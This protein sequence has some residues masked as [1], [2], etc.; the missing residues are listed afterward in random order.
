MNISFIYRDK[1][2]LIFAILFLIVSSFVMV[3]INSRFLEQIEEG[4]VRDVETELGLRIHELENYDAE[5]TSS[6]ERILLSWNHQVEPSHSDAKHI[7]L[8]KGHVY[9][10]SEFVENNKLSFTWDTLL[11]KELEHYL[12]GFPEKNK[13]LIT[14]LKEMR[15][16][17]DKFQEIYRMVMQAGSYYAQKKFKESAAVNDKLASNPHFKN[18][19][20]AMF[21]NVSCLEIGEK[22]NDNQIISKALLRIKSQLELQ[23][24][25]PSAFYFLKKHL[26]QSNSFKKPSQDVVKEIKQL[27]VQYPIRKYENYEE[28]HRLWL[29]DREDL[30]RVALKEKN[31]IK[32]IPSETDSNVL[33]MLHHSNEKKRWVVAALDVSRWQNKLEIF[34]KNRQKNYSFTMKIF[35]EDKTLKS[36]YANHL[37]LSISNFMAYA[38]DLEGDNKKMKAVIETQTKVGYAGAFV[39]F[40]VLGLGLLMGV[41]TALYYQNLSRLKSNFVSTVSHELRTPLTSIQ[42]FVETLKEKRYKNEEEREEYISIIEKETHRLNSLIERLL[43]FSTL[44]RNRK[45]SKMQPVALNRICHYVCSIVQPQFTEAEMCLQQHLLEEEIEI[46]GD[47][48]ALVGVFMNLLSNAIKYAKSGKEVEFSLKKEGNL[49]VIEVSDRGPGIPKNERKRM[50]KAFVRQDTALSSEAEGAGLGLSIVKEIVERHGGTV[51]ILSR[52]GGGVI[53]KLVFPCLQH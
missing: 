28:F 39:A 48:E 50:F 12:E 18:T 4:I 17:S 22:I 46:N 37:K 13:N 3:I 38:G 20:E 25:R 23:V 31:E 1:N 47:G 5:L 16:R 26:I 21:A 7:T 11:G 24:L 49:A 52:E 33:W 43:T 29:Q 19:E 51:S 44:E 35:K 30:K 10:D 40:T 45:L 53:F 41:G 2:W 32:F 42:M 36:K 15:E 8:F 14:D 9:C 27:M 34:W 6:S